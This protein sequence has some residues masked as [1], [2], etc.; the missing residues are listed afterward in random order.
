MPSLLTQPRPE[1]ERQQG[2]GS[3]SARFAALG[4]LLASALIGCGRT[5]PAA[6]PRPA[7]ARPPASQVR[8]PPREPARSQTGPPAG[9]TGPLSATFVSPSQ[10]WVL[11]SVSCGRAFCLQLQHTTDGGSRWTVVPSPQLASPAVA[12]QVRGVRFADSQD[13]WVYGSRLFATHD[14]GRSW[15]AVAL[16]GLGRPLADVAAL[17]VLDG[18]VDAVVVAG[19]DPNTGGP[20]KL[21]V[22]DISRD[23]WRPVAGVGGSGNWGTLTAADGVGYASVTAESF[24]GGGAPVVTTGLHLFRSLDGRSWARRPAPPCVTGIPAAATS[25]VLYLVCGGGVAAGSQ[26]KPVYRS[27]DGGDTWLAVTSAPF[28]GDL[29]GAAASPD[30]LLV[31]WGGGAAGIYAS[32]DSGERWASA[33]TGKIPIG[34][35]ELG[36]TNAAEGYAIDSRSLLVMTHDAG[37]HWAVVRLAAEPAGPD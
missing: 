22:S 30:T 9:Q 31:S 10:G 1:P 27:D 24:A 8:Q 18:F 11:I 36:M 29:D 37:R 26:S 20:S 34:I 6:A 16:P 32:L 19:L 7:T 12:G 23:D 25:T 2:M 35:T 5:A 17:A 15:R 14:G 3:R 33:Y 21:Y 28:G 4:T 13:G